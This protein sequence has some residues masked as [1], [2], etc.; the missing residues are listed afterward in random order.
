MQSHEDRQVG[1]HIEDTQK[2][3]SMNEMN[4]DPDDL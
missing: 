4:E 3:N 1:C 2:M